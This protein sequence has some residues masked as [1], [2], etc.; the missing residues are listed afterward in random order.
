MD[1]VIE[2]AQS[3]ADALAHDPRT[4]ELKEAQEELKAHPADA[5]LQQRFHEAR[6]QQA[7]L[8]QAGRPV[9]PALKREL[10]ALGEQVRRSPVL[11]RLLRAHAAFSGMMDEVSQTISLAVDEAVGGGEADDAVV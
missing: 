4:R 11:Q 5:S 9:E 10:A 7:A 6:Q 2:K 1:P 3:L 8:E